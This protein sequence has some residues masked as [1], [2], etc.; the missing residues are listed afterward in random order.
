MRILALLPDLPRRALETALGP[1]RHLAAEQDARLAM[2][3][4]RLHHC[5]LF[6]LDPGVLSHDEFTELLRAFPASN[7]PVLL[8]TSLTAETAR[9]VVLLAEMGAHE[10]VIRDVD[11]A[12]QL[13]V[14]KLQQ[15]ALHSAP[16]LLFNR[17][18]SRIRIFPE[19]LKTAAVALFGNSAMPRWVNDLTRTTGLG[20]RT[21][22]RWMARS[23]LNGASSLLDSARMAK[24]WELLVSEG[25]K[26]QEVARQL[27]Y[28]RLRLLVSHSHRLVGA[29]PWDFG[30]LFTVEK[31]ANRLA[32]GLLAR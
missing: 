22:D 10:L 16:A 15:V 24:A 1:D 25:V 12:P 18:A 26:P 9:R 11:D 17:A 19:P 21:I 23:G 13:V 8:Y 6:V 4:L 27:G 29:S 28:R 32:R 2:R 14:H 30:R 20:R 31:F 5:D 3:A 7:V